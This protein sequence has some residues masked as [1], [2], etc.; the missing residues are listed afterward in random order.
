MSTLRILLNYAKTYRTPPRWSWHFPV[1]CRSLE[2]GEAEQV[3]ERAGQAR[4]RVVGSECARCACYRVRVGGCVH[5][6]Y[7]IVCVCAEIRMCSCN[8]SRNKQGKHGG[9]RNAIEMRVK[10][11]PCGYDRSCRVRGPGRRADQP[12]HA[13]TTALAGQ[14]RCAHPCRG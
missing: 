8:T 14:S 2:T 7:G 4:K 1:H 11:V 5:H 10:C 6:A 13:V 3:G 9:R 12:R